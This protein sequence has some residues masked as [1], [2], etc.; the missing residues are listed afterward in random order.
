MFTEPAGRN[1]RNDRPVGFASA[2]VLA[3][4]GAE[5]VSLAVRE[6]LAGAGV[7]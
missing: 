4:E 5:S 3:D 2:V 6:A 7:K 1:A